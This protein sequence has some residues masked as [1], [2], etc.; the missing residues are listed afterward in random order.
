MSTQEIIDS[1]KIGFDKPKLYKRSVW[2]KSVKVME[3]LSDNTEGDIERTNLGFGLEKYRSNVEVSNEQ[4]AVWALLYK[5]S[6]GLSLSI[7]EVIPELK[8]IAKTLG[9]EINNGIV[10]KKYFTKY[11]N[12]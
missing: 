9:V 12:K 6:L 1:I 2:N 10:I 11:P 8:L 7:E 4:L 3:F 5:R